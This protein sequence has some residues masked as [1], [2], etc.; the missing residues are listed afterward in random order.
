VAGPLIPGRGRFGR[1]RDARD[2]ERLVIGDR[3]L[4]V[5][6]LS[7]GAALQD[8]RL[9]GL[10]R[11]L[12]VGSPDLAAYEGAMATCGTLVGPV[13]N[14]IS[15]ARAA[16]DGDLCR[17]D[18]NAPGGHTLHGGAAGLHRKH[19]TVVDYDTDRVTLHTAPADG[20]GGFPGR[21]DIALRYDLPAPD[22][23]RLTLTAAT[24]RSTPL[25]LANHSYWR[26]DPGP[27][28]AGHRLTVAAKRY[29]P[30]EAD[31]IPTGE[32]ALVAGTRFD[33]R[34]GRVL[35]D[36]A[37]GPLDVN[38][39][40][41]EARGPLRP[42][43]WLQGASGIELQL[44]TT[45]PGLQVFDGRVLDL[46]DL[47]GHDGRVYGPYSGLALEPQFWP[48]AVN[49]PAFP[50]VLL[51]PGEPWTQITTWRFRRPA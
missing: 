29:L 35:R 13:A 26:L 20:E 45:E 48:D 39:C 16:I 41:A 7:Y 14:R 8:L 22:T 37:E 38:F 49:R 6:I 18:A 21:R 46:P 2:V 23:L 25:S 27:T 11:S 51:R 17:F 4:A 33:F 12:T 3:T 19:W 36:G 15:G 31:L 1:T 24:N 44:A 10:D 34:A 40:L 42:A 5:A 43:A 28:T 30:V 47:R 50:S 32:I 9:S